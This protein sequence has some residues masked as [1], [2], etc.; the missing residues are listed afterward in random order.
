IYRARGYVRSGRVGRTV[1]LKLLE[2]TPAGRVAGQRSA[3]IKPVNAWRAFPAVRY[4]AKR[5]GDTISFRVVQTS[6]AVPGDSFQVDA[7]SLTALSDDAS[8]PATAAGFTVQAASQ[9]RVSLAW[10]AAA[11]NRA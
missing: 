4:T 9:T 6:R 11:D 5:A 2:M 10:N 8:P 3:C 7:L 1:C